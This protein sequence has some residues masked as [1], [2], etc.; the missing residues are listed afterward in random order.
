V[1]GRQLSHDSK[2]FREHEGD[3]DG[4]TENKEDVGS[5]PKACS[6]M[7]IRA[8]DPD[9]STRSASSSLRARSGQKAIKLAE[10]EAERYARILDQVSFTGFVDVYQPFDEPGVG[11]EVYSAMEPSDLVIKGV[12][13][14]PLSARATRL[15]GRRT[16]A[17]VLQEG[18]W[19][20]P[21]ATDCAV[22]KPRRAVEVR[23]G[24]ARRRTM[25]HS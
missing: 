7:P 5:R 15:R 17:S 24:G 20:T 12:P 25:S 23:S 4:Q 11:A 19:A 9:S 1:V 2:V 3:A 10:R 8:L 6:F 21:P 13:E 16:G 18:T 14:P 22:V